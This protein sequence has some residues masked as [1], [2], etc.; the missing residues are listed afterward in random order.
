MGRKRISLL[1]DIKLKV[2]SKISNWQHKLFSTGGKEVLIKTVAQAI[3]AYA[4][5]VF[6]IPLGLCKDIRE[7][8]QG[9]VGGQRRIRREPLDKMRE[10][11]L[12]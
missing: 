3:L 6:K 10:G 5:S 4:M 2:L 11:E 1:N 7:R 8:F 9:L 12:C